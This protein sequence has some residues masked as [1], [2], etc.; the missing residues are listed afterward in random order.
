[1]QVYLMIESLVLPNMSHF[2]QKGEE[3]SNRVKGKKMEKIPSIIY[4]PAFV[5]FSVC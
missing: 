3:E 4:S 1:M 5:V 2:S